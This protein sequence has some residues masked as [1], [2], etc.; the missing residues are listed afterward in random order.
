MGANLLLLLAITGIPGAFAGLL[1]YFSSGQTF[2]QALLVSCPPYALYLCDESKYVLQPAFYWVSVGLIHVLTWTL[3][4]L[5]GWAVRHSWQDRPVQ[6]QGYSWNEFWN[7]LKYGPRHKR[8]EYRRH[9]LDA[10]AFYWLAARARLKPF[11][12]WGVLLCIATWW[13][14]ARFRMDIFSLEERISETN[15][16]TAIMLNV[17][18]KLWVGLEASRP[19]AEERQAG[20]FELLLSTPLQIRDILNGQWLALK[21]QFLGPVVLSAGAAVFFLIHGL[22]HALTGRNV[23]L[24]MWVCGILIFVMDAIALFWVAMFSALTTSSPNQAAFSSITRIVIAPTMVL[25]AVAV[26]RN[27]YSYLGG[28]PQPG[29]GFY[30]AW[31][32]VLGLVTDLSYGLAA[33][34]RLLSR[35][36]QLACQSP[37]KKAS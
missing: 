29:P 27:V 7:W 28:N 23:I 36:R 31:W 19:L 20:S 34:R 32:L 12:V 10:N 15:F 1:A 2:P 8:A 11:H 4:G 5:A 6:R 22:Q 16:T 37:L 3:L 9:L 33:R 35:F 21:R 13:V 18:L 25:G 17:A 24:G 30:L 14:W 26:L